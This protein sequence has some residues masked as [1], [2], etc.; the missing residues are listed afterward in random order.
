MMRARV[1]VLAAA[2]VMVLGG[3]TSPSPEPAP[4]PLPVPTAAAE[5]E[6]EAPA[7]P[8]TYDA[9]RA[10][11]V[12]FADGLKETEKRR[13]RLTRAGDIFWDLAAAEANKVSVPADDEV[14]EHTLEMTVVERHARHLRVV[15]EG[16]EVRLAFYLL[17]SEFREVT[18]DVVTLLDERGEPFANGCGVT[19]PGGTELELGAARAGLR[20]ASLGTE[21]MEA[22]GTLPSSSIDRVYVAPP[23]PP[24]TRKYDCTVRSPIVLRDGPPHRDGKQAKVV[25]ELS[26]DGTRR[27]EQ[28]PVRDGM[29]KVTV[30]EHDV[31]I[32]GFVPQSA[33]TPTEPGDYGIGFGTGGGGGWG[34]SHATIRH[35]WPGDALYPAE[36]GSQVGRV[37]ARAMPVM[38]AGEGEGGR[39]RVR[40][41]F[42]PWDFTEFSIDAATYEAAQTKYDAWLARVKFEKLK[43][44]GGAKVEAVQK[45][46]ETDRVG[47]NGC[48]DDA[49][50][51]QPG[52]TFRLGVELS[53][54]AAR[55][56]PKVTAASPAESEAIDDLRL[57][58]RIWLRSNAPMLLGSRASF[59][60]V[61]TPNA[62][63]DAP[64]TAPAP[65]TK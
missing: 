43:V 64:V 10:P 39:Q 58:L 36:G 17:E 45:E 12:I 24:A 6:G 61:L 7:P 60:L 42:A 41:P 35:L 9:V 40:F 56:D 19:V 46:L 34:S 26:G 28:G 37:T 62:V 25:A 13:G 33:V 47:V 52:T 54:A 32:V 16:R 23:P 8:P 18:K 59:E 38:E 48:F 1:A 2:L 15:Y 27:C 21:R 30:F 51:R 65:A 55:P 29:Q 22:K 3:C 53:F 14:F 20:R 44:T 63:V 4:A 31:A 5:G 11:D 57:C 49:L 50:E